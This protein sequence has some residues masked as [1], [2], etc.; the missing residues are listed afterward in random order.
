MAGCG[1]TIVLDIV[2]LAFTILSPPVD[3]VVTVQPVVLTG[4]GQTAQAQT[5][6][7]GISISQQVAKSTLCLNAVPF[8]MDFQAVNVSS[9]YAKHVSFTV[10]I[11]CW[12][13]NMIDRPVFQSTNKRNLRFT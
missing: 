9:S 3:A 4:H 5:T 7:T 12:R 10:I 8:G 13:S 11:F 2:G 6:Q 1:V